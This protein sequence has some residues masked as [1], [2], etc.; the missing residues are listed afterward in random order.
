MADITIYYWLTFF[1]DNVEGAKAAYSNCPTISAI[2]ETT[3]ALAKLK[4]WEAKRPDTKM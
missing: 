3:G 1:F 2:I 4:E